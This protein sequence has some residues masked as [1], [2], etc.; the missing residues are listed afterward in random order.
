M[1]KRN[2]KI[3]PEELKEMLQE[4]SDHYGE[5]VRPVSEYCKA[6][7]TW[8]S[9]LEEN[10]RE[11]FK[12]GGK[13]A[14]ERVHGAEVIPHFSRI[15]LLI[16]KSNFLARLVYGGEKLRTEKCPV[17][18]GEWNG[19]AMLMGDCPHQCDGSGFLRAKDDPI[20][21]QE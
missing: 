4:L 6:F 3:P 12:A 10:Y 21:S 16:N 15:R 11:A 19:H 9:V 18:K 14:A 20:Y 7:E 13:Q 17:H 1:S 2:S 8:M 5:P